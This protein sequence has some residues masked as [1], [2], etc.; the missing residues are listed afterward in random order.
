MPFLGLSCDVFSVSHCCTAGKLT[1]S[2]STCAHDDDAAAARRKLYTADL[3]AIR[4]KRREGK[5]TMRLPAKSGQTLALTFSGR[6]CHSWARLQTVL[7][8]VCAKLRQQQRVARKRT[9]S[10]RR[11]VKRVSELV[12]IETLLVLK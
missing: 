1:A 8:V 5:K 10:E 11:G 2:S 9:I 4:E 6:H 7:S 12:P 3:K